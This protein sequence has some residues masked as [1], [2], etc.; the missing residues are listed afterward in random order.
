MKKRA[1]EKHI[2][3]EINKP[4]TSLHFIKMLIVGIVKNIPKRLVIIAIT[5][6]V[7]SA[8][9]IYIM[10]YL[11]DG[12]RLDENSQ[13][14]KYILFFKHSRMNR[15]SVSYS[16]GATLFW[17]AIT[18]IIWG[19][20]ALLKHK[21]LVGYIKGVGVFFMNLG[22]TF[23]YKPGSEQSVRFTL[24]VLVG[25]LLG[26][27][28]N[29]P[30][31]SV[32]LGIIIGLSLL[33]D[34]ISA[35]LMFLTLIRNDIQRVKKKEETNEM[36]F[37]LN[38]TI[39][40]G[41]AF[42]CILNALILKSSTHILM[43]YGVATIL[44]FIYVVNLKKGIHL[45]Q[46][47]SLGLIMYLS[48]KG[49]SWAD[50]GGWS[51]A[52]GTLSDWVKSQG[53]WEAVKYTWPTFLTS[54]GGVLNFFLADIVSDFK[55]SVTYVVEG[56]DKYN[57]SGLKEGVNSVQNGMAFANNPAEYLVTNT[58]KII[59][60]N[61]NLLNYDLPQ[62]VKEAEDLDW[63]KLIDAEAYFHQLGEGNIDNIK[64]VSPD[65][66]R[67]VI[68][69]GSGEVVSGSLVKGTYNVY[70]PGEK[71]GHVV[72][73][74]VPYIAWGN[75]TNDPSNIADRIMWSIDAAKFGPKEESLRG[76]T[77]MDWSLDVL[78]D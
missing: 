45:A 15:S 53:A 26:S 58:V 37:I 27:V 65:G 12:F 55:K 76:E 23:F 78:N 41:L 31:L 32:A 75:D 74:V 71:I 68:F 47:A 21:G 3:K 8:A 43:V 35:M 5:S 17:Y 52:G 44:V 62:T 77:F 6:I 56:I 1:K 60:C 49:I 63:E 16:I 18:A 25:Y 66:N 57:N 4:K 67:E 24:W 38:R 50:D 10:V 29:N 46:T 48:S 33:A 14:I 39:L 59:H 2:K 72:F 7:L 61:R 13:I 51:E 22:R 70:G 36:N 9:H 64:F 20:I 54:T 28:G 11:N 34:D 69:N 30:I 42:G 40:Q 73:D 19:N